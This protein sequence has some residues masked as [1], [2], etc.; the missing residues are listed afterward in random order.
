MNNMLAVLAGTL[1]S[2]WLMP[3]AL[4]QP[5]C[6]TQNMV[7][8][9]GANTADKAAP[10]FIDT[11]GLDF[12]TKPPTRD[13][14]NPSYPRATELPDGTLPPTLQ[15]PDHARRE[16]NP[17]NLRRG[18][19]RGCATLAQIARD[20]RASFPGTL[21]FSAR[22][23]WDMRRLYDE[24][25]RPEILGQLVAETGRKKLRQPRRGAVAAASAHGLE[26]LRQLVS[27]VEARS[28]ICLSADHS[29]LRSTS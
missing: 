17:T 15:R 29:L 24:Y 3:T 27:E 21:G 25:S 13:P 18:A 26:I 8:P 28:A 4:A 5:A 20:L 7:V 9:S 23:V 10:F 16:T 19:R 12:S 1:V 2:A 22:N 14:S 11:A 6:V